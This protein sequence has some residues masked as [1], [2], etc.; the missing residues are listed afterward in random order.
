MELST[1]TITK[2]MARSNLGCA[3]CGWKNAKCDIHHIKDVAFGGTND[4]T[5][6]IY[7]CP[8]HHREIH[9]HRDKCTE[10]SNESLTKCSLQIQLPNWKTLYN[11]RSNHNKP[12]IAKFNIICKRD[13]CNNKIQSRSTKY[14][15]MECYNKDSK[16]NIIPMQE[17]SKILI[18][19]NFNLEK[20]GRI[21]GVSG[22]AIKKF[23]KKHGIDFK[24]NKFKKITKNR[25]ID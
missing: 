4:M 8:N 2:I 11:P 13:G 3:L 24:R 7:V 23:C 10:F 14:C 5:N 15:C 9:E 22:A 6:L 16:L 12:K 21:V 18:E 17:L 25:I 1:R 19:N 20:T